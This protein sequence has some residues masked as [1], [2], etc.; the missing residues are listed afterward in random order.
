MG[1]GEEQSLIRAK[2]GDLTV[3]QITAMSLVLDLTRDFQERGKTEI[4]AE[5]IPDLLRL[6]DQLSSHDTR[7]S[8]TT[9]HGETVPHCLRR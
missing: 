3:R 4:A 6:L 7:H 2:I 9:D 5:Y 8:T 1:N